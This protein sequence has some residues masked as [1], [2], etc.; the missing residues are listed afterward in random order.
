VTKTLK[1]RIES[2]AVEKLVTS[3][4]ARGI[5]E[6]IWNAIDDDAHNINVDFGSSGYR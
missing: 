2:D 3:D 1:V 6:L 4:F 5:E